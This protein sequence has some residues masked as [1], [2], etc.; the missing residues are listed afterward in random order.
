MPMQHSTFVQQ[1]DVHSLEVFRSNFFFSED[2]QRGFIGKSIAVSNCS[3]KFFKETPEH[4]HKIINVILCS[5]SPS[6]F[7][8]TERMGSELH[9]QIRLH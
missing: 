7:V 3:E 4:H 8:D 6:V 2:F 9:Q 5:I 1:L